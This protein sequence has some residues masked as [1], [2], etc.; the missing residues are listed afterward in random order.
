M[1]QVGLSGKVLNQWSLPDP[2]NPGK[3]VEVGQNIPVTA[4]IGYVYEDPN[5]AL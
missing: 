4:G 2:R 5:T 1:C 3:Q